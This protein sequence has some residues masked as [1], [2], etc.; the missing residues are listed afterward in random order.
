MVNVP[1][2][3]PGNKVQIDLNTK[4][5]KWTAEEDGYICMVCDCRYGS[6]IS[7]WPCCYP[8]PREEL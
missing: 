8:V 1:C 3:F 4:T 6:V 2:R 5:H 7:E